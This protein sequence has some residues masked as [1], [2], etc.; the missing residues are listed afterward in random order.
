MV[1]GCLAVFLECLLE[2]IPPRSCSQK[3]IRGGLMI[4]T[5]HV[6]NVR[7]NLHRTNTIINILEICWR[8]III[9][10][11]GAPGGSAL[12][13][14]VLCTTQRFLYLDNSALSTNDLPSISQQTGLG[15]L[16]AVTP[17]YIDG[18]LPFSPGAAPP[19]HILVNLSPLP[20]SSSVIFYR[21]AVGNGLSYFQQFKRAQSL[22]FRDL[23]SATG[24]LNDSLGD[25]E[26]DLCFF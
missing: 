18:Q 12:S 8:S 15:R 25:E 1:K 17:R 19:S 5:L 11:M 26:T 9:A 23:L 14:D 13:A 22:R 3:Q 2:A 24:L 20:L 7:C 16:Q 10:S 6:A 21:I 4:V